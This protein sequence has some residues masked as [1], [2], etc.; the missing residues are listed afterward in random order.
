MASDGYKIDKSLNLNP[1][2]SPPLNPTSGDVYYDA[3]IDS[4]AYYKQGYWTSVDSTVSVSAISDLTSAIFTPS[5][6]KHSI[7]KVEGSVESSLHSMSASSSGKRVTLLNDSGNVITVKHESA[8]DLVNNRIITP[9]ED[10]MRLVNGEVAQ[11]LYDSEKQRWLL[12]SVGSGAG[13]YLP[14]TTLA[15]GSVRLNIASP[16]PNAPLVPAIDG[17]NRISISGINSS[18]DF[19]LITPAFDVHVINDTVAGTY[20]PGV[21][22]TG[23]S[24]VISAEGGFQATSSAIDRHKWWTGERT[25]R[26]FS[27]IRSSNITFDNLTGFRRTTSTTAIAR[28]L[29]E[30]LPLWAEIQSISLLYQGA[31]SPVGSFLVKKYKKNDVSSSVYIVDEALPVAATTTWKSFSIPDTPDKEIT[32]GDVLDVSVLL[33]HDN[34]RIH[35]VNIVYRYNYLRL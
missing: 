27:G 26:D 16:T 5:I 2:P 24:S 25:H 17:N 10:D 12:V 34:T 9:I 19:K 31:S 8:A 35:A 18:G 22:L 33:E 20:A 21:S 13:A 15:N 4:F 7:I 28:L 14:A 11:F 30:N 23:S 29:I 1:Q 6:V 32:L 3:G